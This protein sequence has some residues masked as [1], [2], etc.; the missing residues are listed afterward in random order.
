[1]CVGWVR[2]RNPD[3]ASELLGGAIPWS[4]SSRCVA[5]LVPRLFPKPCTTFETTKR[6]GPPDCRGISCRRNPGGLGTPTT[7]P[8]R[9]RRASYFM[10]SW[11]RQ[12]VHSQQCVPTSHEPRAGIG[13]LPQ[14]QQ[15]SHLDLL[16]ATKTRPC[17]QGCRCHL[18][19]F[20]QASLG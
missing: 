17:F 15:F 19:R 16:G 7:R 18:M 5:L 14:S 8:W 3:D 11:V 12:L 13:A 4:T 20:V 9:V 1:M 10:P 6:H 2:A